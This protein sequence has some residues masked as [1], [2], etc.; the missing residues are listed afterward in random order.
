MIAPRPILSEANVPELLR[1]VGPVFGRQIRIEVVGEIPNGVKGSGPDLFVTLFWEAQRF[2]FVAEYKARN[3]PRI[4][5]DALRQARRQA[6]ESGSLPMVIVP[7]LSEQRI[8]RLVQEGV[9]GLDLCG[10]GLVSVPGRL[11]LRSTGKP[12]RYPESRP[13]R[14]AYRGATSVVPRVFLRRPEFPSV[15]SIKAEIE[16]AGAIVALSTVSKALARMA[17]DLVVERTSEGIALLQPEKLLDALR[18]S[19]APPRQQRIAQLK[20]T[21]TLGEFFQRIQPTDEL[22]VAVQ[23]PLVALSGA[24]SQASY[25]AGL[26]SDIP[27]LYTRDLGELSRRLGEAWQPS[28]RYP[29]V[30]V[31]ETLEPTAFFDVRTNKDGITYSSPVQAYIELSNSGDK[32]D[33]EIALQVRSLILDEVSRWRKIK[34]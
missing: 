22:A 32:R 7:F 24:S 28:T 26:R 5:D 4:F 12:N 31:V 2:E 27:V 30:T 1:D 19:F 25:S 14:F 34:K 8:E 9:S 20:L 16:A 33:V 13:A 23:L 10:N 29:D 3:T 21:C 15:A 17:D 11:L 6:A 18:E